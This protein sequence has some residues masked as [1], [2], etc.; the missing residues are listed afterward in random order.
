M[1]EIAAIEGINFSFEP[2]EVVVSESGEMAYV[3]GETKL[4]QVGQD[5][6]IGKFVSVWKDVDGNGKY[7]ANRPTTGITE[8]QR[9][10]TRFA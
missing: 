4:E 3:I 2:T 10:K 1:R 5:A 9:I 6:I 7:E 8:D